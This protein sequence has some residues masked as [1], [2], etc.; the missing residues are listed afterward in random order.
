MA[1]KIDETTEIRVSL[2]TVIALIAA[3]VAA[4]TFVFHIE[5]RIDFFRNENQRKSYSDGCQHTI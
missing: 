5:E 1:H 2:K 3:I 4:S